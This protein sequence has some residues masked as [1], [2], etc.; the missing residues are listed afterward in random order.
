ML[1]GSSVLGQSMLRLGS[2]YQ[3]LCAA[4]SGVP[5]SGGPV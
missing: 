5:P 2:V 3:A 1:L 4:G